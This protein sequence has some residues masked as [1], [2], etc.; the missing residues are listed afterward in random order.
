MRSLRFSSDNHFLQG[1]VNQ[2]I[3]AV[4]VASHASSWLRVVEVERLE[5]GST[6]L[7]FSLEGFQTLCE[8]LLEALEI[9]DWLR[10]GWHKTKEIFH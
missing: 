8:S 1:G 4:E 2:L 5:I 7:L 9:R 3:L 6:H 10:L